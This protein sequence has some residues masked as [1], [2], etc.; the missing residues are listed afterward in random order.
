MDCSCP[1]YHAHSEKVGGPSEGWRGI[2]MQAL[3]SALLEVHGT[4]KHSR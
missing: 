3:F 4:M 1:N 2:Q